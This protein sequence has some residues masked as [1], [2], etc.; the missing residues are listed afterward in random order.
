MILI[1]GR[2]ASGRTSYI[3]SNFINNNTI[4]FD[5][6]IQNEYADVVSNIF[7]YNELSDDFI[8]KFTMRCEIIDLQNKHDKTI[9]ND[10]ND[11]NDNVTIIIDDLPIND[12]LI[13]NIKKLSK[14]KAN[15][16]VS[17]IDANTFNYFSMVKGK[18]I[19]SA[20]HFMVLSFLL[21]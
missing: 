18:L 10:H 17:T 6:C 4:I 12:K 1:Y 15:V 11:N 5:P 19:H 21:D 20:T 2:P 14:L 7:I 13:D 3:K 9:C 8:N 16:I